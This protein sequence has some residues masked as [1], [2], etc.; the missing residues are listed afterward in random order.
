MKSLS[1]LIVSVLFISLNNVQAETAIQSF[2]ASKAVDLTHVMHDDMAFWPGGVPF[3]K[4]V[5]VNYDNGGYL[6]HK[7]TMGENTGTHVDAPA[8][9]I[10]GNL[11]IDK[12]PIN[13]LILPIVV[14]D[15]KSQARKNPDYELSAQDVLNWES[16]NGLIPANSLVAL[17]S[18]WHAKFDKPKQYINMDSENIMHFP[19]YSPEAAKLLVERNVS[20]IGIDTLSLDHGAS[21]TF[22][23]HGVMLKANKYQVE[24]MANLDALP[25]VGATAIIGVLPV[26]GGSQAQARIFALLP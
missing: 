23:T 19:G 26:R 7:F 9:F 20:G 6:L 22:A 3:K 8:H 13:Q 17:N 25:A 2:S 18:G 21:K 10:K 11:V 14:I 24:N 5:I 1:T 15:M 12:L 16:K 4:E